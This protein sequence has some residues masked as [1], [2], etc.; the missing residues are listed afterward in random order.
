MIPVKALFDC[1]RRMINDKWGYIFGTAGI[2]WTDD[3]QDALETRYSEDDP[4]YGMSVKYG[5]QWVGHTVTDCSG[6]VVWIWKQHGFKIPHG[7]SSMVRQGFI[8]DCSD[9]PKPG[10]AALVDPTPG[11]PD[12][13][14]IGIVMEDGHTIFEAR[15][16]RAGCVYGDVSD[17]KWTKFGRFVDVDY[18]GGEH[19][20]TPYYADVSTSSGSLNIRSGPGKEYEKIGSAKKGAT[21]TVITHGDTWDFIKADNMQGYA[22]TAY[23]TPIASAVPQDPEPDDR[24]DTDDPDDPGEG[25]IMNP[26]MIS[27][28]GAIVRFDGYWRIAED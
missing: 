22:S 14:H 23:L 9:A 16:T 27:M 21:V 10:Y 17:P 20:E 1:C 13:K 7:S 24:T 12:N 19:M 2:I 4:N 8:V 3:S 6:A 26:I 11:T 15:G 18:S 5:R 28:S 25:W